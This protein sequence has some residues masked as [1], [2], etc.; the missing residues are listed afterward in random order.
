[1][2]RTVDEYTGRPKTVWVN[3]RQS[4]ADFTYR[5]PTDPFCVF[6]NREEAVK[7][8]EN[9]NV[10]T[11]HPYE[12]IDKSEYDRVKNELENRKE[13][14]ESIRERI[15]ECGSEDMIKFMESVPGQHRR[16]VEKTIA[17]LP[18][19]EDLDVIAEEERVKESTKG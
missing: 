3:L 15:Q 16:R 7:R 10:V 19:A 18:S 9:T 2:I 6:N 12:Y 13:V 8:I 14:I 5:I 4:L 17:V 11:L 1:M